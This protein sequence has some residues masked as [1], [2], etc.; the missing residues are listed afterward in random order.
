MVGSE[1]PSTFTVIS[2]LYLALSKAVFLTVL[3][4]TPPQDE[5][6]INIKNLMMILRRKTEIQG[7][8]IQDQN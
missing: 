7:E 4:F 2:T 1:T 5:S 6:K 8:R 3:A